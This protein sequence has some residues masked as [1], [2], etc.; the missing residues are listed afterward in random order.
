MPSRYNR[1]SIASILL[2]LR[3]GQIS[4]IPNGLVRP[5]LR[6]PS[7]QQSSLQGDATS[8][9]K[10]CFLTALPGLP[11]FGPIMSVYS[12]QTKHRH[13]SSVKC[14]QCSIYRTILGYQ[15]RRCS[16]TSWI[17]GT[18]CNIA[19]SLWKLCRDGHWGCILVDDQYNITGIIDWS[20][21]MTVPQEVFAAVPGFR[22]PRQGDEG[23][24]LRSPNTCYFMC[25]I[26]PHHGVF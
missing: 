2:P 25:F 23:A 20:G 21:V 14:K 10:S 12:T 1:I 19:S 4:V 5:A 3:N 17:P 26:P 16:I 6:V 11:E 18:R 15:C 7:I 24:T 9:S 22:C 8:Y 13:Y